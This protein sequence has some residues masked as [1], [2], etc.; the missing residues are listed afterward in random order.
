MSATS[1]SPRE[2]L[3]GGAVRGATTRVEGCGATLHDVFTL[4]VVG[5]S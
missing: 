3:E 2:G 1:S 5:V 4:E